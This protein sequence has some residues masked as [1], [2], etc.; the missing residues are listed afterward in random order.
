MKILIACEKSQTICKAFRKL[1]YEAYSCDILPCSMFDHPEW[2]IQGD[3]IKEAYSGKYGM[4]ICHPPCTKL[5]CCG[6]R[7]MYKGGKLN[8]ARLR[9]AMDAKDFFMKLYNAPIPLIAV[10][11]PTPLKIVELP[12]H[13]QVIQPYMFGEP[14]SKRTLLW[15][16]GLPLLTPTNV[17]TEY[18]PFLQSGADGPEISKVR[19]ESRSKTFEGIA[20]AM[21]EQWSKITIN[22]KHRLGGRNYM[23]NIELSK[24]T[25]QQLKDFCNSLPEEQLPK[26]VLWMGEERGGKVQGASCFECDQINPTGEGIENITDYDFNEIKNEAIITYKGTPALWVD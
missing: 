14:Y 13:T 17:L 6:A 16:K 21:A 8:E 25:W 12:E 7:H 23:S 3:A 22:S 24:Y 26:E 15:L 10:E 11:N 1:G 9:D 20:A 5:S 18:K 19:G 4:M 2:H